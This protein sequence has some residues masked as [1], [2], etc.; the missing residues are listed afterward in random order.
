MSMQTL[1]LLLAISS[2]VIAAGLWFVVIRMDRSSSFLSYSFRSISIPRYKR[3]LRASYL[4]FQ[5]MPLLRR[6]LKSIRVQLTSLYGYDEWILRE[7]SAQI[8]WGLWITAITVIVFFFWFEQDWISILMLVLVLSIAES[9]YTDFVIQ[10]GDL[11]LLQQSI[12]LFTQIRHAYQRHRMVELAIEEALDQAGP[13][14]RPHLERLYQSQIDPDGDKALLEYDEH[15]PNRHYRLF[16][17]LSRLVSEYGDPIERDRST[18]LTG[19]SMLVSDMQT[20]HLMRRKLDSLLKG[21]KMIAVI[22]ILFVN[23]I[24]QWAR[25]FFP[26]MNQFYDSQTGWLIHLL[27]FLCVILCHRLLGELQWRQPRLQPQS[28]RVPSFQRSEPWKWVNR[29]VELWISRIP[30]TSLHRQLHLLREANE[31]RSLLHWYRHRLW[32]AA[33]LGALAL[34]VC[35]MLQVVSFQQL[36]APEAWLYQDARLSHTEV[37][38]AASGMDHSMNERADRQLRLKEEAAKYRRITLEVLKSASSQEDRE[39]QLQANIREYHPEWSTTSIRN[40]AKQLLKQGIGWQ[41][42]VFWWWQLLLTIVMCVLG[43]HGPNVLLLF[44]K[45][46]RLMEMRLEISHFYSII[47]LLRSFNKMTSEQ[48]L[49]WMAR[50]SVCCREALL[51]CLLHWDSG[52]EA[53]LQEL[54]KDIPYPDFTR[55]VDQLELAHDKIPLRL[56]FDDAEQSWIYEQEMRK[57]QEEEAVQ[58]KAVWGQWIGF[59]PMYAIIFL[60]LVMPLMWLSMKQMTESFV[61][62][63]Q[64]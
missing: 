42:P 41:Q 13:A 11:Q 53:A 51:K 14:V 5:R 24:E 48:L 31:A 20:E 3:G 47:M 27:V 30:R 26:N 39:Q 8:M 29:G 37:R 55:L 57:Q 59:A 43:Y 4:I 52:A 33:A 16:A 60:Y 9:L 17:R 7:K 62:I 50:S 22:P 19:L 15:A 56:A 44:K 32:N 10:R 25:S 18:Y 28:S 49:E 64:L 1:F 54:R 45:K 58:A 61:Q 36:K 21:L 38:W 12:H 23:P 6:K 34:W 46:W 63:N 40:Y 35:I 2:L